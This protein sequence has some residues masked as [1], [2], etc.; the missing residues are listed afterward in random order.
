[1]SCLVVMTS[2]QKEDEE[3]E[4]R[5]GFAGGMTS[6]VPVLLVTSLDVLAGT[7][8]GRESKRRLQR[9]EG[10]DWHNRRIEG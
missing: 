9:V 2:F 7:D 10:P 6:W 3:E 4:R 8:E 1:M 5:M